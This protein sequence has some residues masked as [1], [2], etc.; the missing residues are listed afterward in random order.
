MSWI[1]GRLRGICPLLLAIALLPVFHAPQVLAQQHAARIVERP[2]QQ[3]TLQELA[4]RYPALAEVLKDLNA[5]AKAK[6]S[7]KVTVKLA[8]PYAP[9]KLLNERDKFLQQ[10]DL[11]AAVNV[12]RRVLP[13]ATPLAQRKG[14]P[15]VDLT[16]EPQSLAK[17]QTVPGLSRIS[18]PGEVSWLRDLA[19]IASGAGLYPPAAAPRALAAVSTQ[20]TGRRDADPETAPY[21]VAI[22]YV[23]DRDLKGYFC[24]GALVSKTFVVTTGFCG[25]FSDPAEL[26]VVV[27]RRIDGSGQYYPVKRL[28][29]HPQYEWDVI[30][31]RLPA[32]NLAVLELAKP[33]EGVTPAT[34]ANVT[35]TKPGTVLQKS[36]YEYGNEALPLQQLDEVL[37]S[38]K[39][40][41][42]G[43]LLLPSTMFCTGPAAGEPLWVGDWSALLTIDRGSGQRD[44][45][46]IQTEFCGFSGDCLNHYYTNL[47]HPG[48]YRF[49][50]NLIAASDHRIGFRAPGQTVTEEGGY[51]RG[52]GPSD[53]EAPAWLPALQTAV[54]QG[55]ASVTP[56]I[57]VQRE[58][59]DGYA[60]VRYRTRVAAPPPPV[61]YWR[62]ADPGDDFVPLN[63]VLTF[64]PGQK[65]ARIYLHIIDD[66]LPEPWEDFFVELSDPSPGWVIDEGAAD[67][68]VTIARNDGFK[69]PDE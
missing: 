52:A 64:V 68:D 43:N 13:L 32:Y 55:K 53:A 51:F 37:A 62:P 15:Y 60:T 4:G 31:E 14:L 48:I 12:V 41:I 42:C 22:F 54:N 45:L 27:T 59:A 39:D 63:G 24:Q 16:L 34:L 33:V 65:T 50:T 26:A 29:L 35:P 57:V 2:S 5:E 18:R 67:S 40:G 11:D 10:R 1:I 19:A 30:Y 25:G 46:G 58:S 23:G 20:S 6:G 44:L 9:E 3:G 38:P 47:A 69:Y 17:L 36:S 56:S 7:V 49:I 66:S 8:V 21:Q 61:S 28:Y